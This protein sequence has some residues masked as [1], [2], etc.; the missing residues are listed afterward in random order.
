MITACVIAFPHR[1]LT[2]TIGN[3][4]VGGYERPFAVINAELG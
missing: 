4:Y 3:L 1:I 2:E